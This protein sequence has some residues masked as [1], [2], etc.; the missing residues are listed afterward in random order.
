MYGT[1]WSILWGL[2]LGFKSTVVNSL[3]W[4]WHF[5]M[6]YVALRPWRA[7][8]IL[9][10]FSMSFEKKELGKRHNSL[11]KDVKRQMSGELVGRQGETGKMKKREKIS[12]IPGRCGMED[13]FC[14]PWTVRQQSSQSL[15]WLGFAPLPLL[16]PSSGINSSCYVAA[17]WSFL[18]FFVLY[19]S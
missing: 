12:E 10:L 13:R 6:S 19:R 4:H 17:S 3:A 11:F 1:T 5:Q 14:C 15:C 18:L 9:E 2:I 7:T 16:C 8:E